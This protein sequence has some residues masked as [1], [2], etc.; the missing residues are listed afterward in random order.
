ML[1]VQRLIALRYFVARADAALDAC[2]FRRWSSACCWRRAGPRLPWVGARAQP[3][4]RWSFAP[5]GLQLLAGRAARAHHP[6]ASIVLYADGV[7]PTADHLHVDQHR[8]AVPGVGGDGDRAVVMSG[9][10]NDLKRKILGNNAHIVVT[11]PGSAVHR[12]HAAA[13]SSSRKLKGVVGATPYMTNEVMIS[14][15]SN[16]SGVVVKGI[17]PATVGQVTDLVKNIDDGRARVP[18]QARAAQ[19]R[20]RALASSTTTRR[21]SSKR[22]EEGGRGEEGRAGEEGRRREAAGGRA[23]VRAAHACRA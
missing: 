15:Q 6:A 5:S 16:L 18:D 20:E 11:T 21:R 4:R 13:R 19:P 17:D 8:R 7:D 23:Q 2:S 1:T 3:A 9:F 12:L 22:S 10:E 14:S